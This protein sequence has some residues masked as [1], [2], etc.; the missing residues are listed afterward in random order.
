[1]R[2]SKWILF[3]LFIGLLAGI[4]WWV[5]NRKTSGNSGDSTTLVVAVAQPPVTLDPLKAVDTGSSFFLPIIHAPL[6]LRA[7]DGTARPI[8]AESVEMSA[9]GMKCEILLKEGAKFWDGSPVTSADV[10][11]SFIRFYKSGNIFS[12][13]MNRIAGMEAVKDAGTDKVAGL[14][15]IDA[16]RIEVVFDEP[17][18][19]WLWFIAS[20][21]NSVLKKG[22][23]DKPAL[24]FD[25]HVVGAGPIALWV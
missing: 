20:P 21:L 25:Q 12:W 18:P 2:T 9:D 10:V 14:R 17:D 7:P 6:L 24:A 5:L 16:R 8:L 22:S 4:S 3:L 13:S 11:A 1:M 15:V 23:E 19:D